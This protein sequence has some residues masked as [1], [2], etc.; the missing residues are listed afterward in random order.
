MGYVSTLH[1]MLL[2]VSLTNV[3]LMKLFK[4]SEKS[5]GKDEGV[6]ASDKARLLLVEDN[7]LAMEALK[8]RMNGLNVQISQ[9]ETAGS[10]FDLVTSNVFDLIITDLGLPDYSG[11]LL[12]VKVREFEKKTQRKPT[13][14]V[15][16]TGHGIGDVIHGCKEAGMSE[17]YQKPMDLQALRVL[18][19]GVIIAKNDAPS[20]ILGPDLP[21]T[22]EQLF[23]INQ[24][25]VFDRQI[26]IEIFGSEEVTR[27][28][29]KNFK[30]CITEDLEIIKENHRVSD[31]INIEKIAHKMKSS[32]S[33]GTVKLYH[34]LLY[35]ERY[36]KAGHT[37]CSDKLFAQ[38]LSTVDETLNYLGELDLV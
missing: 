27:N 21:E 29:L 8:I 13:K 36:L 7:Y 22:E 37:R 31:W 6:S 30:A 16:L 4:G 28:V 14:I 34:A 11:D 2:L 25:P 38:M 26:G 20:H 35:L 1:D 9:A 32:S 23:K 19:D 24:Y 15:G 12:A 18:I 33:F 3:L 17:V 10:A 5:T